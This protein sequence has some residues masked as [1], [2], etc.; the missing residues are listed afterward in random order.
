MSLWVLSMLLVLVSVV[1]YT[2]LLVCPTKHSSDMEG[3]RDIG[4]QPSWSTQ[5]VS[6]SHKCMEVNWQA[7]RLHTVCTFLLQL[8][9]QP[10]SSIVSHTQCIWTCNKLKIC[11]VLSETVYIA[12]LYMRYT[13]NFL[14]LCCT[15]DHKQRNFCINISI[16]MLQSYVTNLLPSVL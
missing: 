12:V 8:T 9:W 3:L 11:T 15:L 2:S 4:G 16:T 10:I 13:N 7:L 14:D 6:N 1:L 5:L